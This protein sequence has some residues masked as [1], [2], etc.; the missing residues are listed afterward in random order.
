MINIGFMVSGRG[1]NMKAVMDGC[2]NGFIDGRPVAVVESRPATPAAQIATAH[3]VP[4]HTLRRGDPDAGWG[5]C[6]AFFEDHGVDVIVLAGFLLRVDGLLLQRY[7]GQIINVH[8]ALLPR[9]GGAGMYGLN[10]HQA[11]LAAGEDESGATVHLVDAHYD[12]GRIL[13]QRAISVGHLASAQAIAAA[14][15]PVEHAL[16]VEVVASIARGEMPL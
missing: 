7:E 13:G 12:H 4:V 9:Y 3:D 1:S 2:A 11:V 16:L 6:A 15:L 8:P 5:S 10:V 14:V